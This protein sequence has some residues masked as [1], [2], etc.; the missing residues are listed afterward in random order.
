[1][2]KYGDCA[3]RPDEHLQM[4]ET[5]CNEAIKEFCRVVVSE[6][7]G[8]YLN[9]SATPV[10]KQRSLDLMKMRG[11]PGCFGSWDCKHFLWRNF[12]TRLAG[13]YKGKEGGT[14]SSWRRYVIPTSTSGILILETRAR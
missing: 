12:P 13:Q 3:E 2:I 1:M 8:K 4:S 9:R 10:E 14:L 7:R 6:F 11:F 5:V